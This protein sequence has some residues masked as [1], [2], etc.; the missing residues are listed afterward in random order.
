MCWRVSLPQSGRYRVFITLAAD[1]VSAGNQYTVTSSQGSVIG[2]VQDTGSYNDFAEQEVGLLELAAGES[3][4]VVQPHGEL[5]RELA[6]V[7]GL[8]LE[9]M[10]A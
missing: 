8:R 1:A 7:R 5:R 4:I 9:R 10:S 3:R 6:D 2:T